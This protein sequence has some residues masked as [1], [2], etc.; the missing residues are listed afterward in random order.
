MKPIGSNSTPGHG[1]P[2]RPGIRYGEKTSSVGSRCPEFGFLNEIV[3]SGPDSGLST[4]GALTGQ[5][6]PA[7]DELSAVDSTISLLT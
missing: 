3:G 2:V 5:N 6:G 1:P 7:A 4:E